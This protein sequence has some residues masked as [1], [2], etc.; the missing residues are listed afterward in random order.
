MNYEASFICKV[1]ADVPSKTGKDLGIT[2][3]SQLP[4][5]TLRDILKYPQSW[6]LEYFLATKVSFVVHGFTKRDNNKLGQLPK[7]Y[8][9]KS[10]HTQGRARGQGNENSNDR[11][12]QHNHLTFSPS[13]SPPLTSL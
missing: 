2:E 9:S 7:E 3:L 6:Y 1:L 12:S 5:A 13:L 11:L 8:F 10:S 4:I